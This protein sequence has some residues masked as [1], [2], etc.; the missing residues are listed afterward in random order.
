MYMFMFIPGND[1]NFVIGNNIMK[2]YHF[3][4]DMNDNSVGAS[5]NVE[6][7]ADVILS[8]FNEQYIAKF[9]FDY[10]VKKIIFVLLSLIVSLGI[11]LSYKDKATI[12]LIV[13]EY[14]E[15]NIEL[16]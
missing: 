8:H 9:K 10:Y 14:K 15:K 6:Y 13:K 3:I 7:N 1:D 12:H 16:I 2:R 4:F 11:A 5:V